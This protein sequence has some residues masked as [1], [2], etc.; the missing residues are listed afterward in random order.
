MEM[1]VG[2]VEVLVEEHPDRD[3]METADAGHHSILTQ[4]MRRY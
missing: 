4:R 2:G 1:R 3:A